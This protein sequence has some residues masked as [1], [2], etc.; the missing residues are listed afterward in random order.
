MKHYLYILILFLSIACNAQQNDTIEIDGVKVIGPI[1]D[2]V[3]VT[4]INFASGIDGF[5]YFSISDTN[6]H[7]YQL[8]ENFVKPQNW[9]AS[10]ESNQEHEF[11]GNTY[12]DSFK[13]ADVL[14]I[15][16][17][18]TNLWAV[19]SA[20]SWCLKNGKESFPYLVTRLSMKKKVGLI[21]TADLIIWDRISTGDLEFYGHGAGMQ[22]DIFTIAG[23]ASWILNELTGEE[24]AVVHGSLSEEQA[25]EYKRQWKGYIDKLKQ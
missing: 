20:K 2:S 13:L 15:I 14:A 8:P 25:E 7:L 6:Y 23:R 17:T 24:F 5:T 22:E 3:S 18:S 9:R 1:R 4:E 11:Y 10:E 12:P 21:N 19:C 16:D